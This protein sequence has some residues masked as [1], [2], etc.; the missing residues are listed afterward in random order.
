MVQLGAVFS[1]GFLRVPPSLSP[2]RGGAILGPKSV[3]GGAGGH[4]KLEPSA[5]FTRKGFPTV[6]DWLEEIAN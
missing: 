1:T 4:M 2:H 6:Q 3:V 5:K